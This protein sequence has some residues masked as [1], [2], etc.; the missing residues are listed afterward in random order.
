MSLYN[1]QYVVFTY[2]Y[3]SFGRVLHSGD[4]FKAISAHN[5]T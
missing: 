3:N 1:I 2:V 5:I 4:M